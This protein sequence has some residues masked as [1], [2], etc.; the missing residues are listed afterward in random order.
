MVDDIVDTA[1]T[2]C[3]AANALK[4]NGALTVR[5]YCT[6]AVL[7]GKATENIMNSELDELVITDTIPLS[8]HIAEC[9]KVRQLSLSGLLAQAIKRINDEESISSMFSD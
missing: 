5:A 2:L 8:D 1:G 4:E 6:H 9:K 3:N 7:S